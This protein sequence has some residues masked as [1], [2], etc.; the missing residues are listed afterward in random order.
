MN[1]LIFQHT[2]FPFVGG[3]EVAVREITDRIGKPQ[4]VASAGIKVLA[5]TSQEEN[6]TKRHSFFLQSANQ[7]EFDLITAKIYNKLSD[8]EKI[9]NVNV[10][11]VGR[12]WILDKYFYPI[13]AYIKAGKLHREKRY[14]IAQGIMATWGGIA[15]LLFKLRYKKVKYLLTE[16]SGDSEFFIWIRTWFWYPIYR[17]VYTKADCAQVISRWLERRVRRYGCNGE[18]KIVPNG[19]NIAKFKIKN[20][21]LQVREELGFGRNDILIITASRLVEKNGLEDLVKGIKEIELRI[22]NYESGIEAEKIRLLIA[23]TGKL[24]QKLKKLVKNLYLQ[25]KVFFL[26]HISQDDLPKYLRASDVFCRP[27]L[28][29]GFGNSFIEAMATGIPVIATPVGGIPDFLEDGKTG[30]FCKVKNPKSIA[31]SIILLL[32]DK[33]LY[34]NIVENARRMVEEKYDWD[35]I[36]DE[37]RNIYNKLV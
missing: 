30:I 13:L 35:I 9:G 34:D 26:G 20:L 23:G 17:M 31:D 4:T 14:D 37:M 11:R 12:G 15:A 16:Q 28:T 18:I 6:L 32:S 25:D 24:E 29:E 36:A 33:A 2:Y 7:V 21:K 27:S 3:A 5:D 8:Y 22:K 19:V 10:Y 1:I